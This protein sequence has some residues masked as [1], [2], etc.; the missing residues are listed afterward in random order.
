MARP[1]LF[2]RATVT[3]IVKETDDART[4][5]LAPHDGPFTYKSGQFCTFRVNV[6]GT[7]LYRSYSMSSAPETDT[8]LSVDGP[9][10]EVVSDRLAL[11]QIFSNLI[12]NAAKYSPT[13]TKVWIAARSEGDYV[14]VQIADQYQ[15][16]AIRPHPVGVQRAQLPRPHAADLVRFGRLHRVRMG[17]VED[18]VVGAAQPDRLDPDHHPPRRRRGGRDL[19]ELHAA[20]CRGDHAA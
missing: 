15:H 5:V 7:E 2:Q 4:Y 8:E 13:G 9:L 10:P 18:V 3:R 14:R 20:G 12:E 17:A 11:E 16:R 6:D 1:P 19:A